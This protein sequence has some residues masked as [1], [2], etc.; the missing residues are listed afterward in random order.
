MKAFPRFVF[1][2]DSRFPFRSWDFKD[3]GLWPLV[4]LNPRPVLSSGFCPS[5]TLSNEGVL[6]ARNTQ[7]FLKDSFTNFK[8]WIS[9]FKDEVSLFRAWHSHFE[10]PLNSVSCALCDF[11]YNSRED[12]LVV[13]V[14]IMLSFSISL[15]R[16][17]LTSRI[18]LSWESNSNSISDSSD[19]LESSSIEIEFN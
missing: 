8:F 16:S 6:G 18:K 10:N 9:T 13:R 3:T 2:L 19:E 4:F 7:V 1:V 14:S 5:K 17:R 12:T 15:C 11:T